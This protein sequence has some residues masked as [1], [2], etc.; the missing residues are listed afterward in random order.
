MVDQLNLI[1]SDEPKAENRNREIGSMVR[2]LK[3]LAAPKDVQAAGIVAAQLNRAGAKADG[4]PT[5]HDFRDCGEIEAFADCVLLPYRPGNGKPEDEEKREKI[6]RE[7]FERAQ[8]VVAKQKDG[9]TGGIDVAFYR[10]RMEY[11]D[12]PEY[13]P[14]EPPGS[15]ADEEKTDPEPARPNWQDGRTD[16]E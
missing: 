14:P 15:F 8:I 4:P 11:A 2:R 5:M 9:A 7:G 3:A 6:K 13:Q 12:L 1:P 10:E 16:L